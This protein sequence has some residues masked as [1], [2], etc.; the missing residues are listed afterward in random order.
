MDTSNSSLCKNQCAEISDK[1]EVRQSDSQQIIKQLEERLANN[2]RVLLQ[3]LD[4]TTSLTIQLENEKEIVKKRTL[5]IEHLTQKVAELT[6]KVS[7]T[8]LERNVAKAE[9]DFLHEK[10]CTLYT[11][12]KELEDLL[13]KRGQT[14]QTIFLNQNKDTRFYNSKEGL[15]LT[16]PNN[17]KKVDC[18]QLYDINYMGLGLTKLMAFTYG[19]ET[20]EEEEEE[21]KRSN[22]SRAEIPFNYDSLNKSYETAEPVFSTDESVSPYPSEKEVVSD[23]ESPSTSGSCEEEP[24]IPPLIRK[25]ENLHISLENQRKSFE[26]ERKSFESERERLLRELTLLKENSQSGTTSQSSSDTDSSRKILN[27][28]NIFKR[29][30][31]HSTSPLKT[32]NEVSRRLERRREWRLKR[33]EIAEGKKKMNF[34]ENKKSC[35]SAAFYSNKSTFSSV[36]HHSSQSFSNDSRSVFSHSSAEVRKPEKLKQKAKD[37]K[38]HCYVNDGKSKKKRFEASTYTV[39]D[40]VC[41]TYPLQVYS[42]KHLKRLSREKIFTSRKSVPSFT[43]AENSHTPAITQKWVPKSESQSYSSPKASK[44]TGLGTKIKQKFQNFFCAKRDGPTLKWVPKVS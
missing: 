42:A 4:K 10:R 16:N 32:G 15:G 38:P 7:D 25:F 35:S 26:E 36:T 37:V 34:V 30:P 18:I 1:L 29:P 5:E 40:G 39:C 21:V 22:P 33:A 13:A 3:Q 9:N 24:Y 8:E 12:I 11:K 2:H 31:T 19:K 28:T 43:S 20:S 27:E 41:L 44:E 14:E 23:P 17:L 6:K